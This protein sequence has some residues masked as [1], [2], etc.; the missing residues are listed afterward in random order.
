MVSQTVYL[1]E[2]FAVDALLKECV[3][4]TNSPISVGL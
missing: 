4:R 1:I 3:G 2:L